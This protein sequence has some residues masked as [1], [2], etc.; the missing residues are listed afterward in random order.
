MA[1]R[2]PPP[3]AA[4]RLL[5][6]P[7]EIQTSIFLSLPNMKTTIALRLTCKQLDSIYLCSK[8]KII[9]AQRERI[10]LPFTALYELLERLWLPDGAS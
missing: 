5:S 1:S 3:Q 10:T 4:G 2:A 9:T 6:L 7:P 8:T